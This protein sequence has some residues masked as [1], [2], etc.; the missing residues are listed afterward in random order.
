MAK[1]KNLG[2]SW[3]HFFPSW[4]FTC[5]LIHADIKHTVEMTNTLAEVIVDWVWKK[6]NCNE[7]QG[8]FGNV[9]FQSMYTAP[10]LLNQ[11][12]CTWIITTSEPCLA[13]ICI[14]WVT[15][16]SLSL[17]R[18][19]VD[20]LMRCYL[21]RS[22]KHQKRVVFLNQHRCGYSSIVNLLNGAGAQL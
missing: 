17:Q 10:R 15:G 8:S 18:Y 6:R 3:K 4:W 13:D 21:L 11:R 1:M 14:Y 16:V 7:R 2:L 12:S 20:H 22:S 19:L 5:W 9:L